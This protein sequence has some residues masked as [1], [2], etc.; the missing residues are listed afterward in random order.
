VLFGLSLPVEAG[1]ATEPTQRAALLGKAVDCLSVKEAAERLACLERSV[2]ALDEAERGRQIVVV[3]KPQV[4]A[5]KRARFGLPQASKP[6]LAPV[7]SEQAD[8]KEVAGSIR[9]AD[10][11]RFQKWVFTLEDGSKWQQTDDADLGRWPKAGSAVLI[12]RAALGSY[13]MKVDGQRWLKVRR[14]L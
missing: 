8:L 7:K 11:D 12:R 10:R 9:T 5:D 1:A 13:L 4:E 2:R 6:I 14:Q 3:D